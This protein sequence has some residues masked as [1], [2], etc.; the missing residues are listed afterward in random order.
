MLP[1]H[2]CDIEI[3]VRQ[4]SYYRGHF[5]N[6][7]YTFF[8]RR[9]CEPVQYNHYWT[10]NHDS[11]QEDND[12]ASILTAKESVKLWNGSRRGQQQIDCPSVEYISLNSENAFT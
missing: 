2:V 11:L 7:R 5:I 12:L 4:P 10:G 9:V 6:A 3:L 1:N 8:Q